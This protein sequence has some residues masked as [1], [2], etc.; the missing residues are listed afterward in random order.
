MIVSSHVWGDECREIPDSVPK[1]LQASFGEFVEW[2]LPLNIDAAIGLDTQAHHPGYQVPLQ[3][4]LRFCPLVPDRAAALV[5]SSRFCTSAWPWP[6]W[7]T[8]WSMPSARNPEVA[9]SCV[10]C[11][12]RC[13]AVALRQREQQHHCFDHASL[14]LIRIAVQ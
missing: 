1:Q 4:C 13:F 6:R 2:L 8:S 14:V 5:S 3:A 11:S 12:A 7:N 10:V 9:Q